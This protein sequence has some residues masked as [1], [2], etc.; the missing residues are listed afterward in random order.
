MVT[1]RDAEA[2]AAELG[3]WI[4][5]SIS[6][7]TVEEV[8]RVVGAHAEVRVYSIHE[9]LYQVELYEPETGRKALVVILVEQPGW[10]SPVTYL[11]H[12][13]Q[14]MEAF[15]RLYEELRDDMERWRAT[16]SL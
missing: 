5:S 2:R 15:S 4:A 7:V 16:Q 11:G 3:M 12:S 14:D 10:V 13:I 1:V 8:K 9:G 6:R